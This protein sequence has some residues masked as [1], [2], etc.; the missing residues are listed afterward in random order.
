MINMISIKGSVKSLHSVHKGVTKHGDSFHLLDW[1][2]P[3]VN[4]ADCFLQ[5]NLM[6]PKFLQ[7]ETRSQIYQY[8]LNTKK[9]FLVSESPSFR[10]TNGYK[11]LGWYSYKWTQGLFGNK[12]S[13]NDR[14]KKFQKET[15]IQFKDWNSPGNNIL[16][17]GQKEGDSSLVD[18]YQKYESFYDW[19][20]DII[21]EI[22]RYTD[23]PIVIRPHPRNLPRG[24]KLANN[25]RKK[26]KKINVTVSENYK[27][28]SS[29]NGGD[30]LQQ[31]LNNAY[32]T[33]TYNSLS[34]IESICQG[35]PTFAL[36]DGSMIWPIAHKDLSKIEDLS[37]DI[38]ITQWCNDIAYTQ[39]NTRENKTGESWAHLKPLIFGEENV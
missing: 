35:I 29:I 32:C 26:F 22:R 38:D 24:K 39:W 2:N 10:Q 25:L 3:L 31:D 4:E 15:G 6:K 23:R 34:A 11:R 7:N 17:M 19:V 14:W 20:S 18:L 21:I 36:D 27:S 37:Y 28:N 13:P 1:Q 30:G 9:P 16:I 5:T 8:I 12:N 33:I